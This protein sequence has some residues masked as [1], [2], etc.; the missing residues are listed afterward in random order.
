MD[1]AEHVTTNQN[2]VSRIVYSLKKMQFV[3]IVAHCNGV[4]FHPLI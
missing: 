3:H 1:Q 4:T 2:G